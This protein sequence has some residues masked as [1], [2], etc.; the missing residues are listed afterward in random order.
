MGENKMIDDNKL[1]KVSGGTSGS[2]FAFKKQQCLYA[3]SQLHKVIRDYMY[4][5]GHSCNERALK[6]ALDT[7]ELVE[8]DVENAT[9][10]VG[11]IFCD[12]YWGT[13]KA[14][15][16]GARCEQFFTNEYFIQIENT[17]VFE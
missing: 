17:I 8:D 13:F 10:D 6:S 4:E 15:L 12:K 14:N 2:D 7:L 9:E 11:F 16:R 5:C 3:I 1:E